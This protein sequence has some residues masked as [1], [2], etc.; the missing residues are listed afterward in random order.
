M[1]L[2]SINCGPQTYYLFSQ[3]EDFERVNHLT[4]H[5]QAHPNMMK[6]R[7]IIYAF[8]TVIL[9]TKLKLLTFKLFCNQYVCSPI[10]N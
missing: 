5:M 10:G 6:L 1:E 4:L 2:G 3:S 7:A 9:A 8:G